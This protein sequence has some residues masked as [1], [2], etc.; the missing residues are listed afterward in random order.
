[1]IMPAIARQE[2]KTLS[3]PQIEHTGVIIVWPCMIFD[4]SIEKYSHA[5]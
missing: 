4:P 2:R 5:W 1:M 3:K